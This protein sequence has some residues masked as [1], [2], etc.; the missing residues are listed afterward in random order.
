[1]TQKTKKV[2]EIWDNA[3]HYVVIKH[4]DTNFNPYKIYRLFYDCGWHRKKC[5]NT[6]L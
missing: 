3:I 4:L 2:M 1:M 6:V 5:R